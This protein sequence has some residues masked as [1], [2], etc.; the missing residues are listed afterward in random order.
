[1]SDAATAAGAPAPGGERTRVG[2][3]IPYERFLD[4]VHCGLCLT[5]CPTYLETGNENDSPRGR[6][7]LMRAVVDGRLEV[8][9]I[10]EEHLDRCLDCRGCE[11]ACPSGVAYGRILEPFR[12]GVHKRR[13]PAAEE[14]G[15]A[16]GRPR[17]SRIVRHFLHEVLPDPRRLRRA[18]LPARI[19]QALHLDGLAR[20]VLP[21]GLGTLFRQLPR[22]PAAGEALPAVAPAE[23]RRRARVALFTGCVARA[24]FPSLHRATVRVLQRNGCEVVVPQSQGCCGAVHYHGG[25]AGSFLEYAQRNADAFADP[26]FD[27]VIVNVAG[28][29]SMLKDYGAVAEE[30]PACPPDRKDQLASL[31]A[32]T[33]DVSEFLVE[34]GMEPPRGQLA[35]RV[36]YADACHLAHAQG[37]RAAPR[38]LLGAIPGLEVAPLPGSELCC[39]AAGSYALTEPDMS[40]KLATRKAGNVL[41]SGGRAV[42][43]ANV[44]CS[45]QIQSALREAGSPLPV[46]HPVT[47]LD[48]SYRD[49]GVPPDWS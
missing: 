41:L 40:R 49:C 44:G 22:I 29:G 3:D 7:Y 19:L 9:D 10:V 45:M 12:I 34:L 13:G 1:M 6:I 33:K 36:V 26:S 28:C 24:L 11:S 16:P 15:R 4:C 14:D 38:E 8:D 47:L 37:I 23:G 21:G 2:G 43:T 20:R 17:G 31:A 27:A 35:T 18:L 48:W 46:V 30:S 42:V 39:G 25:E 5:A 32:K